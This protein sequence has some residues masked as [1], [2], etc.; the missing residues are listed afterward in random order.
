MD[1]RFLM[2]LGTFTGIITHKV[3]NGMSVS[4]EGDVNSFL[5][6]IAKYLTEEELG[7]VKTSL[8]TMDKTMTVMD[9]LYEV[10]TAPY[11]DEGEE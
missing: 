11:P 9:I 3:K 5:N 7:V 10:M 8:D 6:E 1:K 4:L 2:T